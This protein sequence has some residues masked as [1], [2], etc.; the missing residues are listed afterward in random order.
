MPLG[1]LVGVLRDKAG[2]QLDR[3]VF[4]AQTLLPGYP[5]DSTLQKS[6]GL[7]QPFDTFIECPFPAYNNFFLDDNQRGAVARLI[8]ER[9]GEWAAAAKQKAEEILRHRFTLL[10]TA[11]D[12]GPRIDWQRDYTSGYSW[13]CSYFRKVPKV[14]T[15]NES[16][17]KYPWELSRFHQ[18]V[19]LGKVFALTG[20]ERYSRE[21]FAQFRD[22]MIENPPGYGV[23]WTCTMEVAIRAVNIIWSFFFF[24]TSNLFDRDLKMMLLKFLLSHGRFIFR[25]LELNRMFVEGTFQPINGN[26]YVANLAGLLYISLLFPEFKESGSWFGKAFHEIIGEIGR[27][28][29]GDG[30]HHELSPNYHRLVLEMFLSSLLLLTKH[31]IT[32]PADAWRNVEKM[33]DFIYHYTKPDQSMPLIRDVDNGRFHVLGNDALTDHTHLLSMGAILFAKPHL[34]DFDLSED[35]LWL[36]GPDAPE[37]FEAVK[38]VSP[39]AKRVSISFPESGVYVLQENR[40]HMLALCSPVGLKGVNGHAH[41][42]FLSFDLFAYDKTFLTDCGSFAYTREPVW[43]N[44]FRSTQSHNTAVVDGREINPFCERETFTL[45]SGARLH[46][47]RW[48]T[49]GSLDFLEARYKLSGDGSAPVIHKRKF[50]FI[51]ETPHEGYWVVQD[52]FEGET[53]GR[54]RID[55]RFHFS[56]G[57]RVALEDALSV[58]T[59]CD[60]GANLVLIPL[61][62]PETLTLTIETGWVSLVY[63]QKQKIPVA[64]Y[65]YVGELP[66]TMTYLLY[67][68]PHYD[69]RTDRLPRI[70]S[71]HDF[72][73]VRDKHK[74]ISRR[75]EAIAL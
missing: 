21:F 24:K 29:D 65:T 13:D 42:D 34:A 35:A 27:Q 6:L 17:I 55:I 43:R 71:Y 49:N 70:L 31:S 20:D 14:I 62:H 39:P 4:R 7:T 38:A 33:F 37:R 30:V 10:G 68:V 26:H 53:N 69:E 56:Q 57:I 32:V 72:C 16:D 59:V 75:V 66:A 64:Q 67:P 2:E 51:K 18:G 54:H 45:K 1:E 46:V 58:R 15:D 12:T 50:L 3:A 9:F 19:L 61:Q 44:R 23:N 40:L 36:L 25:N 22:W 73:L 28:V 5:S 11:V 60:K 8:R 74:A 52:C 48:E 41:N 63:G 47:D